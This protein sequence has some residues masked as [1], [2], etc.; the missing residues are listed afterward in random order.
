MQKRYFLLLLSSLLLFGCKNDTLPPSQI[1]N[2]PVTRN[3]DEVVQDKQ[4]Q[5]EKI[6]PQEQ[7]S[8]VYHVTPKVKKRTTQKSRYYIIVASCTHGER[9]KAEKLV[10][11]L[12]IAGYDA[13]II[14]AKG[15]LRVSIQS[16]ESEQEA[17]EQRD[18]YRI[19]TDRADL[20]LLKMP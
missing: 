2:I 5:K 14:D 20:W 9:A 11:D 16:F 3:I 18:A 7:Q 13:E 8:E 12:K 15:R 6:Q 1:T 19:A 10:N 17:R 4:E